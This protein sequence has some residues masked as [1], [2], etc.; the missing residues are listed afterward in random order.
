MIYYKSSG[1]QPWMSHACMSEFTDIG[2]ASRYEQVGCWM[3]SGHP[4]STDRSRAETASPD[5]EY[6][7][8]LRECHRHGAADFYRAAGATSKFLKELSSMADIE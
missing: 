1:R 8:Q 3:S 6:W 2:R 4:L 5:C 7:R